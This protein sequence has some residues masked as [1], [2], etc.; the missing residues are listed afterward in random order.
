[1]KLLAFFIYLGVAFLVVNQRVGWSDDGGPNIIAILLRSDVWF[2]FSGLVWL[3]CRRHLELDLRS[4]R[5]LFSIPVCFLAITLISS[6]INGLLTGVYVEILGLGEFFKGVSATILGLAIFSLAKKDKRFKSRLVQIMIL[7]PMAMIA[8]AI[9]FIITGIN[10]ISGFNELRDDGRGG[11]G[12]VGLG[13]R[14]QGLASN[15]NIVATQS[16]IAIGLL[17]PNLLKSKLSILKRVGLAV[18]TVSLCAIILWTGVRG[19]LIVFVVMFATLTWINFRL[20]IS[21]LAR[22]FGIL[23]I[24]GIF[25]GLMVSGVNSIELLAVMLERLDA[26]DGRLF[27]WEHYGKLLLI[28]PVGFGLG[29]ESIINTDIGGNNLRLP[30]HNAILQAGMYAGYLGAGLSILVIFRVSK[31]IFRIRRAML[32]T[33]V[34]VELVGIALAWCGLVVNLMFGGMIL[35]DFNFSILS[36]LLLAGV[37][38][39]AT[40]SQVFTRLLHA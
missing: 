13:G 17:L 38:N 9:F 37:S 24:F 31:E 22:L 33:N 1:M 27:L 3:W 40:D 28:N 16:L 2:A 32:R 11:A 25:I 29:F 21:G 14:F 35:A 18:Y 5:I 6:V 15:A 10:N 23:V 30:P 36:A 39:F 8:V 26:E 20:S 12:I 34:P 19:S 4:R 7:M